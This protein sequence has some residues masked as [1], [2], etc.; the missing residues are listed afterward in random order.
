MQISSQHI[1][2][3]TSMIPNT[4]EME[5]I[6]EALVTLDQHSCLKVAALAREFGYRIMDFMLV[7]KMCHRVIQ[8]VDTK[9]ADRTSRCCFETL[10]YCDAHASGL[11]DN[12]ETV[13]MSANRLLYIPLAARTKSC[14][15]A[16]YADNQISLNLG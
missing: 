2:S 1:I 10:Y 4:M 5:S 12:K 11:P 8:E 16:G 7:G 9:K 15:K 3:I 13:A 6:V 14:L